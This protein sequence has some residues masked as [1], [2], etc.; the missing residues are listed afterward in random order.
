ML[1]QKAKVPQFEKPPAMVENIL[2][3]FDQE[4]NLQLPVETSG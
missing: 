1:D 3:A 2:P 4:V